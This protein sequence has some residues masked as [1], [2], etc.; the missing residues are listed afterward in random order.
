M[1][2]YKARVFVINVMELKGWLVSP[3]WGNLQKKLEK[4]NKSKKC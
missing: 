1:L 4:V 3:G 2:G